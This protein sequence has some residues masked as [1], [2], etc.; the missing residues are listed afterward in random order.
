[1]LKGIQKP[2][3]LDGRTYPRSSLNFARLSL[4]PSEPGTA[5]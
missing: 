3:N 5:S 1:M 2:A 4:T